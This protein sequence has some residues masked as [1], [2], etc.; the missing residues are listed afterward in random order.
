MKMRLAVLAALLAVAS[1]AYAYS[2]KCEGEKC[3]VYCDNGTYIGEMFWNGSN[4]SDGLRWD[5]DKDVV[6]KAM[7]KAWGTSCQ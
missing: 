1:T 5:P 4:W 2:L 6:A 3:K 7:V